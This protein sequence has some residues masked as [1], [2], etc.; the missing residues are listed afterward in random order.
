MANFDIFLLH[1]R[2]CTRIFKLSAVLPRERIFK[3]LA[4][5]SREKYIP[6]F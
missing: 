6:F 4:I 3:L 1:P 5:F 2:G